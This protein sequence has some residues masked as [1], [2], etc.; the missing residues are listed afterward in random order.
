MNPVCLSRRRLFLDWCYKITDKE[1]YQITESTLWCS[2]R[3][4]T[5]MNC[6]FNP[7]RKWLHNEDVAIPHYFHI[8][9]Y[10]VVYIFLLIMFNHSLQCQRSPSVAASPDTLPWQCSPWWSYNVC[11][12]SHCEENTLLQIDKEIGRFFSVYER[13]LA[14]LKPKNTVRCDSDLFF[15]YWKLH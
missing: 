13:F 11:L 14:Y 4:T 3:V 9:V 8:C 7:K 15:F 12:K 6:I 2:T 1:T 5:K 10:S